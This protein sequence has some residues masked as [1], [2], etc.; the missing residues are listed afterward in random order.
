MTRFIYLPDTDY[1]PAISESSSDGAV[2]SNA[3][4][5]RW[6]QR[7][8]STSSGESVPDA[9][10]AADRT[11][12]VIPVSRI[13]FIDAML[14]RVS[15]ARR[16]QLL[17]FAIE[18]KL[19]IDPE[20]VH[21]VEVGPADT[22]AN[23]FVVAAIDRA[24]LTRALDWL[25]ANDLA[26]DL[27]VPETALAAVGQGEWLLDLNGSRGFA[28]RPDGLA[29]GIDFVASDLT[30]PPFS[31][32]LALNEAAAS[33][34]SRAL[35][36]RLNIVAPT[37]LASR[38]DRALWEAEL[39]VTSKDGM[40]LHIKPA[41][42]QAVTAQESRLIASN[43]MVGRFRPDTQNT[44]TMAAFKW[45]AGLAC[46]SILIHL[47]GTGADAWRVGVQRRALEN[48]IRQIFLR[49]F[50]EATTVVDAP[51]QMSRNLDQLRRE[52]G[53]AQDATLAKLALAA[54]LTRE[55][56]SNITSLSASGD[57]LNITIAGLSA[58]ASVALRS[59]AAK[60]SGVKISEATGI[61]TVAISGGAA[62]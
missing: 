55:F 22:G 49:S 47:V 14:P 9:I 31:L 19:T 6:I 46:V 42:G 39:G 62:P 44:G 1:F 28:V 41:M 52:R 17:N 27:A 5:I 11:V 2:W 29:Y 43:F 20:T 26:A 30:K 50:P 54:S 32:S 59:A 15:A 10:P 35:P 21:A 38:I 37:E 16:Q 33:A 36:T 8:T 18:D 23:Q 48:D 53:L 4:H 60:Q 13:A 58:D 56:A 34:D 45:A 24:W 25:T 3:C 57:T 51:L 61:V 12:A 7:G 40:S